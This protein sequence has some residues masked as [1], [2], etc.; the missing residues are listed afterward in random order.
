[1]DTVKA[2]LAEAALGG[3]QREDRRWGRWFHPLSRNVSGAEKNEPKFLRL[4][5]DADLEGE[6]QSLKLL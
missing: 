4:Q 1:M 6:E 2:Q 5:A 3:A